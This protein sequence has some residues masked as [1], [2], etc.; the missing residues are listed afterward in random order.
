MQL[1]KVL[2]FKKNDYLL[3][4]KTQCICHQQLL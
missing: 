2:S 1:Q 4:T 3:L